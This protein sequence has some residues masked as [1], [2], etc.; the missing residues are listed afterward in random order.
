MALSRCRVSDLSVVTDP[1][2]VLASA[3]ETIQEAIEVVHEA[4]RLLSVA[5]AAKRLQVCPATVRRWIK[6]GRL[7]ASRYPGGF[8]IKF[9]DLQ[10]I[11][12]TLVY[13][14]QHT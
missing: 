14:H 10:Q 7:P 3:Q 6:C 1:D 9:S 8:K 13:T 11:Q 2:S 5:L 4:N 12:R